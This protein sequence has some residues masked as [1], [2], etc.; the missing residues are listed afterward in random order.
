MGAMDARNMYSNLAVN[1]Y[2]HAV[3][4]RRISSTSNY[5]ARNHEYKIQDSCVLKAFT[6][7]QWRDAVK[8]VGDLR[9]TLYITWP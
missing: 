3:A 1:K 9:M 6:P 2:L 5:D 8:C 7:F 4:S